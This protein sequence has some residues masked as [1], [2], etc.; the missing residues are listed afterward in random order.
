VKAGGALRYH[1]AMQFKAQRTA[2][3]LLVSLDGRLDANSCESFE[4]ELLR[5]LD[6]G[7]KLVLLDCQKLSFVASAG[8][9][10]FLVAAK[11]LRISG[12]K[13]AFAGLQR[14]VEQVFQICGFSALFAIHKSLADAEKAL[15]AR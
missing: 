12:G 5:A 2:G 7:D 11:R 4:T 13:L 10:V 9:R 15:A 14:N 6:G 1:V 8:L 3:V